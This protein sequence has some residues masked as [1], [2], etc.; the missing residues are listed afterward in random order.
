MK[1]THGLSMLREVLI[2]LTSA[3]EGAVRQKFADAVCLIFS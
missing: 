3:E 2:E 1:G